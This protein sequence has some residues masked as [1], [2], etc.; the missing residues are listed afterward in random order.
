MKNVGSLKF[1][2]KIEFYKKFF[3]IILL[4]LYFE[5]LSNIDAALIIVIIVINKKVLHLTTQLIFVA[6]S[7]SQSELAS[8]FWQIWAKFY[9]SG[10]VAEKSNSIT[11]IL[12]ASLT[13]FQTFPDYF[14]FK[15]AIPR[16]HTLLLHKEEGSVMHSVKSSK[17]CLIFRFHFQNIFKHLHHNFFRHSKSISP[18]TTFKPLL[19][20]IP[21][22]LTPWISS[23]NMSVI[24]ISSFSILE[25]LTGTS[26]LQYFPQKETPVWTLKE[27]I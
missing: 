14:K 10:H 8:Q 16:Y 20:C 3:L 7:C 13:T 17:V 18:Y 1:I 27:N 11:F 5:F 9:K 19:P 25:Y 12:T 15:N 4:G 6:G 24:S 22:P 2:K 23:A 21:L 26:S